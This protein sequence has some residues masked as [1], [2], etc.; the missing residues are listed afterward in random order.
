MAINPIFRGSIFISY[1]RADAPGYVRGLLSDL[2]N[3]FGSN[4]VFLDMEDIGAGSDFPQIIEEAVSNC[5]LLLA[6]IGPRWSELTDEHGRR[7][8]EDSDDFVR[9]EI[10]AAVA[11]KIPIIPVL[12]ENSKMPKSSEL[13]E[14]IKILA[15]L[16]GI[17]L[18]HD[19]WEDDMSRLFMAIENVTLEPQAARL[20]SIAI[21]NLDQGKWQEALVNFEAINSIQPRYLD[22]QEKLEPLRLL[23][24]KLSV[25]G[26]KVN[27]WQML[28]SKFPL[29]FMVSA[30]LLPNAVAATFNYLFNLEVIVH[31]LVRRGVNHAEQYYQ[32]SAALVNGIGFLLGFAVFIFLARPVCRG[33]AGVAKDEAISHETLAFLRQRSL[34]LGKY[35]ALISAC[36]WVLAGPIYPLIINDLKLQDYVFFIASLA[37]CGVFVATY[38]F[39]LV[40][41]LCT[42]VFYLAFVAPG[43]SNPDDIEVLSRVDSWRWRYLAMAGALPMIVLALGVILGP[44]L[45]SRW[46]AVL[47]GLFGVVGT[48]GFFLALW[49]FQAIQTDIAILKEAIFAYS[50]KLRAP[51]NRSSFS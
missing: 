15:A 16:Q 21:A 31:P 28:A 40:T 18:T 14:D 8:I 3:I 44:A 48:F 25:L 33:L 11:R 19:R 29:M 30:S 6:I 39:L 10:A 5:E 34:M 43:P 42:H 4:Q 35:I 22:V 17:S 7:R 37:L 38:P 45:G 1:R 9:L 24:K 49:L 46:G 2:R 26:P 51:K 13:P 36:L 12:V 27:R 20:Y 50:T 47:L 41:W 32:A 23:A